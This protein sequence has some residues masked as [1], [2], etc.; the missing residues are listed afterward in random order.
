MLAQIWLYPEWVPTN[1]MWTRQIEAYLIGA[2]IRFHGLRMTWRKV[3][4]V[5]SCWRT[6]AFRIAATT[7]GFQGSLQMFWVSAR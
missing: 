5:K 6:L 4:S 7:G 2:T 1:L 3:L